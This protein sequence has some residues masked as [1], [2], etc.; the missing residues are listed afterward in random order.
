MFGAKKEALPAEEPQPAQATPAGPVDGDDLWQGI[1]SN[2]SKLSKGMSVALDLC[3]FL[4]VTDGTLRLAIPKGHLAAH[5]LID[6]Q[7]RS[8]LE[9]LA[10]QLAGQPIAVQVKE[11]NRPARAPKTEQNTPPPQNTSVPAEPQNILRDS[12]EEPTADFIDPADID[13]NEILL[14]QNPVAR[15]RKMLE[16]DPGFREKVLMV[17][18]FFEGKL[19]DTNGREIPV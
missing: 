14:R 3:D 8:D 1:L 17:K 16:D 7:K 11:E 19:T 4:G 2:R 13:P 9:K 5:N 12:T 6:P 18:N 10:T 15:T